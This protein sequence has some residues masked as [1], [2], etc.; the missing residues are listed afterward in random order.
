MSENINLKEIQRQ[1]Y[2]F[3]AEDGLADLAV[4][5]VIIGFG[6]F[7]LVDLPALVGLLGLVPLL[8]WYLGKQILVIPRVGFIDPNQGMKSRFRDFFITTCLLGIGV[9][10]FFLL[11]RV[12]GKTFLSS[13]PLTLFGLVLA[14]G[15][16]SLGMLLKAVR[17]YL[18]GLLIFLAMAGGESLYGKVTA[19][20]PF[21]VGVICAGAV[22]LIAGSVLFARFLSKYPLIRRD[23]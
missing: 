1:I 10:V 7:L 20:D 23:N 16:S 15:I 5:L 6:I 3:Y 14:L 18:Y 13:Y 17:F 12:S 22:I 11:T 4:G 19:V 9:L 21:L 8:V 2:L